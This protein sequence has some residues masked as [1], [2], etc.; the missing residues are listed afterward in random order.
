VIDRVRKEGRLL[1]VIEFLTV[2][3]EIEYFKSKSMWSEQ[4]FS[5]LRAIIL[6]FL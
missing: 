3:F 4:S 6:H 1:P 2:L 5:L